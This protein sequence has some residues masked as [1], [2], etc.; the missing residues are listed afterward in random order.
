[1]GV[2]K[3]ATWNINGLRSAQAEVINFL[4]NYDI[5][6]LCLQEVKVD[7]SRLPEELRNLDG[8][9]SYWFHADKP[10]YSGVAIYSRN[11]PLKIEYGIGSPEFD[12]EGRT[13][14]LHF[15]DLVISNFY[16]PHSGRGLDRLD[17]K[18]KMNEQFIKFVKKADKKEIVICGDLNV[19]HREIDLARPKDNT[20][21]A[22]F[23]P[24]ER[25]WMDK[26]LGT[27]LVDVFRYFYP[28]KKEYTWWSQRFSARSRNIG[29]RID[30]FLAFPE[31]V[32]RI[33][34]I[35]ILKEVL[36][37][38]HCPVVIEVA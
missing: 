26:F 36:G 11:K 35:A 31:M 4:K 2:M 33:K 24:E 25:G 15:K 5:D 16:F 32:R 6:I 9:F 18:F 30:Y 22:G 29:W 7:E 13:I 3:I 23:T 37:S 19:A 14:T 21:N 28:E 10:G 38:D 17:F 27:G 34:N 12:K 20:K 8:Y 1:M